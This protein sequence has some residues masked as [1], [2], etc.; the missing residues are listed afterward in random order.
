MSKDIRP[1][2]VLFDLYGTLVD[3]RTDEHSPELW[4]KLARFLRYRGLEADAESLQKD[5]FSQ[6]RAMQKGI[7]ENAE[8]NVLNIFGRILSASGYNGTQKFVVE[9]AQLFRALSIVRFGPFPD[10]LS[11]LQ[12]LRGSFKLGLVSDAQRVFLEPEIKMVGLD[13][14]LDVVVISS[15]HGF[16]KPDSRL[17]N[18]ALKELGVAKERA[19]YVGD[20]IHRDICGA[21]GVGMRA[22]LID[23]DNNPDIDHPCEFHR[24]FSTLDELRKWL[25]SYT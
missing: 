8:V 16:R 22:I 1:E 20:N 25:L 12:A 19:L 21:Q 7:G 14:L 10:T 5:F 24:S 3:I 18:I 4:D 9:V 23:R 17:F 13:S 15:D 2:V 6:V 11:M